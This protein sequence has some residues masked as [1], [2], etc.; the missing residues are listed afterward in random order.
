MKLSNCQNTFYVA[1][2]RKSFPSYLIHGHGILRHCATSSLALD[3]G[4]KKYC[5]CLILPTIQKCSLPLKLKPHIKQ[6]QMD[7]NSK[8]I[9]LAKRIIVSQKTELVFCT[10][11]L[12]CRSSRLTQTP[13]GKGTVTRATKTCSLF[14]SIA[15]K[16][17][18]KRFCA[19][20]HPRSNLSW[21]K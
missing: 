4:G 8:K 17:V 21:N 16:R 13:D 10:I 9:N 7:R 14:C 15:A 5:Q 6:L 1:S 18:E 2:H 12:K 20:Y 19:F 11:S 3:N